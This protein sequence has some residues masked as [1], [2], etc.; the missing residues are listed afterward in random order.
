MRI[1][2]VDDSAMLRDMLIYALEE[3]GYKDIA[4]A[5]NGLEGLQKAKKE[6]FDLIISDVNMPQMN[7]LEMIKEIRKIPNYSKT[8][9]LV[10]TTERGKEMKEQGKEAG[11]TGWIVKPFVP[12]QLLK[13][14]N[15]VLNK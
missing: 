4:F 6:Q 9:I 13:I 15:I 14:V 5:T 8:P 2:I 12:D 1:L 7:G 10:L 3:G 11:A